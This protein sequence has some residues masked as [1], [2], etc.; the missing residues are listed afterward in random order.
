MEVKKHFI[1]MTEDQIEAA[2][3]CLADMIVEYVQSKDLR[4]IENENA[5]KNENK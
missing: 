5:K 1:P 4:E 3:E 2:A